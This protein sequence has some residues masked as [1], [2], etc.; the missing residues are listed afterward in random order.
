M[1]DEQGTEAMQERVQELEGQVTAF[2]GMGEALKA[3]DGVLGRASA[4]LAVAGARG[5][6]GPMPANRREIR[7]VALA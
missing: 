7:T 6:L 4:E 5:P 2:T 3:V 1:A